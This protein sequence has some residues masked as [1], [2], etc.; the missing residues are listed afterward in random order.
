MNTQNFIQFFMSSE[1]FGK[2]INNM[3]LIITALV[4]CIEPLQ[5]L[6][7]TLKAVTRCMILL[8]RIFYSC[9]AAAQRGSWPPQC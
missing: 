3:K 1:Y 5:I 2:S 6:S 8:L 7:N 9:G 4:L